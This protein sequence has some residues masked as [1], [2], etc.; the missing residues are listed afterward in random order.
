MTTTKRVTD[1]SWHN[2][3]TPCRSPFSWFSQCW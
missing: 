1:C 3:V 2:T